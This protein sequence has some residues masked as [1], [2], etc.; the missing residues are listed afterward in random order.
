MI[1]EAAFEGRG[2]ALSRAS[3]SLWAERIQHRSVAEVAEWI[4]RF[5][6]FVIEPVEAPI[7]QELGEL[8]VL[9][10]VRAVKSRRGCVTL[11]SRALAAALAM[12]RG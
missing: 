7:P 4:T 1:R 11:P 3:A 10:G 2:C 8:A 5:A 9:V 12:G 6:G